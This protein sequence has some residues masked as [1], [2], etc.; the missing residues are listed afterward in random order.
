MAATTGKVGYRTLLKKYFKN[1]FLFK[2]F[3][4]K[5]IKKNKKNNKCK[6]ISVLYSEIKY[7]YSN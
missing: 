4:L 7:V 1:K 3:D 5:F 2:E 6:C